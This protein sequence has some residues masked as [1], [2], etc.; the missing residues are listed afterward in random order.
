[1]AETKKLTKRDY[2]KML[3][4]MVNGNEE[5]INFIDHELDLLDRKSSKSTESKLQVENKGIMEV[6][7]NTLRDI[8]K[9]ATITDIQ[10]ANA[11]LKDLSNQKMSA[12]LKKLVDNGDIVRINDKKKTYFSIAE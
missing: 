9:P 2:F 8:A 11:D 5:L 10:N 6:I 7:M 3:K 1:M 12:L 4:G